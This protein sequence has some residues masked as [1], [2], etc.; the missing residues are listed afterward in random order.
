MNWKQARKIGSP[1]SSWQS[2][3]SGGSQGSVLGAF[4]FNIFLCDLFL[5]YEDCCF[6]NY[7]DDIRPYVVANNIAEVIKNNTSITHKRFNCFANNQMKENHEKCH[8]KLN[9]QE[10]ENIY[11]VNTTIKCFKAKKLLKVIN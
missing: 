1:Y 2:I 11:I 10:E 8:L 7:T 3:I 5:Q 6:T 4:F 9:T